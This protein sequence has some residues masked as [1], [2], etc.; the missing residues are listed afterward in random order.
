MSVAPTFVAM[1]HTKTTLFT[2]TLAA[3]LLGF[4]PLAEARECKGHSMPDTAKFGDTELTLNGMGIREA[5]ILKVDVYVAG[6]Y[7]EN[8]S[9]EADQILGSDQVKHMRLALVRDVSR[10]EM[11]DALQ[12]GFQKAAG[13]RYPQMQDQMNKL[14]TMIPELKEGDEIAFTYVPDKGMQVH[15]NRKLAG[16]IEGKEFAQTFLEI[17]LGSDPPNKGLR[18]G[19]LG[20]ECG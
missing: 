6:L 19:L 12:T 7:L 10:D 1:M 14:G 11:F 2:A 16:N 5:T 9:R 17:W 18:T 20:G 4:V 3:C 15:V 13:D 8:P